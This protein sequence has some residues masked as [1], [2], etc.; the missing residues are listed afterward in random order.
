M[1]VQASDPY[2]DSK[3][4]ILCVETLLEHFAGRQITVSESKELW[5]NSVTV[6]KQTRVQWENN[7]MESSRAS[8]V[9]TLALL[10]FWQDLPGV[11]AYSINLNIHLLQ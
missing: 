3:R 9:F 10:I 11:S 7:L 2:L 8:I 6:E 5:Q 4:A 1:F